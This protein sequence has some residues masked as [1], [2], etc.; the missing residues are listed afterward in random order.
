[1]KGSTVSLLLLDLFL[2]AF[3]LF[4]VAGPVIFVT[5]WWLEWW[6]APWI[7]TFLFVWLFMFGAGVFIVAQFA[8]FGSLL[9]LL[10]LFW[11]PCLLVMACFCI[12]GAMAGFRRACADIGD[13]IVRLGE[14]LKS[15]NL[16]FPLE[17][18]WKNS[19]DK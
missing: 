4:L 1:M 17:E 5:S 12:P 18:G 3:V 2:R 11:V 8:L 15:A 14:A 6:S 7:N 10:S 9:L 19:P 16:S 13:L